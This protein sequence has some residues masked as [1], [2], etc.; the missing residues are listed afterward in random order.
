MAASSVN[1]RFQVTITPYSKKNRWP[2]ASGDC[3]GLLGSV[4]EKGMSTGMASEDA[5]RVRGI[6]GGAESIKEGTA[7]SV[8]NSVSGCGSSV[9]L[10]SVTGFAGWAE[11]GAVVDRFVVGGSGALP[12]MCGKGDVPTVKAFCW[13]ERGCGWLSTLVMGV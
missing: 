3:N 10:A 12:T 11:L 4:G 13:M 5:E 2:T 6:V 9:S 1:V 8:P 7:V